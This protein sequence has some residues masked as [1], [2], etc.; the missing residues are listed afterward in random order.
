MS[1]EYISLILFNSNVISTAWTKIKD[2]LKEE[3]VNP[4]DLD[5][6]FMV[7]EIKVNENQYTSF[8]ELQDD[9]SHTLLQNAENFNSIIF[10]N[11]MNRFIISSSISR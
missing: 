5:L 7:V 11:N 8:K 9:I 3:A 6:M 10:K 2:V 1:Q 4:S